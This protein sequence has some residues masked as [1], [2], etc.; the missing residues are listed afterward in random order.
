MNLAKKT[1]I[2]I[3][4]GIILLGAILRFYNLGNNSFTADEFLDINSSMAYAKTGTWQNWDFNFGRINTENEFTARD[5]RAWPYK[6]QVAQVLKMVEPTEGA[7]RAVS[8]IWGII[9]IILIYYVATYFTKKKEVG[10]LAAFLFAVSTTG[11]I[12]DRR[13]RMYA[14]FFPVYLAFSWM[15]FRFLEEK[16]EGKIKLVK[17]FYEKWKINI[18]YLLPAI[19]LGV[20]SILVH[21]LTGNI[22]ITIFFYALIQFILT[23]KREKLLFNKYFI[24]VAVL[25]IGFLVSVIV[26][27][28]KV[29]YFTKELVFFTSHWTYLGKI[30]SDYSHPLLAYLFVF[31]GGYFLYKKENMAKESLW[32]L[33]SLFSVLLAAILI[34]KRNVG[35]QYIFFIESFSIILIAAGIYALA[36]FSNA[37][38]SKY[39][40]RALY[41]PLILTFLILPSWDYFFQDSNTYHQTSESESAN[42]KKVFTYFKKAKNP[43]DVLITRNFRNYYWSGAEIKVFDFGGELATEKLSL[44]EVKKI[45]TENPSGWMII[46]DNDD[47]YITND[48]MEYAARNLEKISNVN[49][50]GKVSVYRWQN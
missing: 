46:S 32:L 40:K 13:L 24:V 17:T 34:W 21:Q 45:T 7:A 41:L 36:W 50:R 8:A 27:P 48:A 20:I 18:I 31:C 14:M 9:S 22:I 38:L 16:Y 1:T 10:L 29:S 19:I 5:E 2:T 3:F 25:V 12:F 42:Y 47:T 6:W 26:V 30:V 33:V 23:R 11:I 39:G 4:L 49:V 15:T 43:E 35:E 44:D 37:N 28:A